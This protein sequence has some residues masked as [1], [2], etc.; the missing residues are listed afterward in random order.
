MLRGTI[1]QLSGCGEDEPIGVGG[2]LMVSLL[3]QHDKGYL[4][5]KATGINLQVADVGMSWAVGEL[6]GDI[7][8]RCM[9]WVPVT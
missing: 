3:S 1:A 2:V 7:L 9:P 8:S 6:S 5:C 4:T